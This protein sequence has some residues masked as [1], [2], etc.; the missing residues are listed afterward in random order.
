M[1]LLYFGRLAEVAGSRGGEVAVPDGIATVAALRDWID[2]EQPELGAALAGS[3]VRVVI[4]DAYA[5]DDHPLAGVTEI[6]FIPPVS[7]G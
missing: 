7:G 4:A 5:A 2:R 6:A 1:R 3:T